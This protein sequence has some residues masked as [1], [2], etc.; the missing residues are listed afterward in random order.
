VVKV[1]QSSAEAEDIRNEEAVMIRRLIIKVRIS[2]MIRVAQA[3]PKG[4]TSQKECSISELQ[5]GSLKM[6]IA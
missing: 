4:W 3:G 1:F 6:A 2:L 5:K